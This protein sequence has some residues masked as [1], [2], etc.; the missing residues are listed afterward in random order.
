MLSVDGATAVLL[1]RGLIDP[2]WI[3]DGVLT[4]RAVA[5][6][7]RNL[8]VEGPGG[9]GF[10]LKQ[11]DNPGEG[12]Y[13]PLRREAA[14]YRFCVDETALGP[15]NTFMPRLV[16]SDDAET[17]L[18]FDLIVGATSLW[19]RLQAGVEEQLTVD[20]ARTLGRALGTLHRILCLSDWQDDP[21]L[22]R[23]S[24]DLPWVLGVHQP[25][26]SSLGSIS[27]ANLAIVRILQTEEGLREQFDRLTGRWRP[28][29]VIHGDIRLDNVLIRPAGVGNEDGT[30]ELW[31]ADWEAVSFGDPA[32]DVAGA[33]QDFL[34]YWVFSMP[35]SDELT[36]EQMIAQARVPVEGL[37]GALRA[38]WWG[39]KAGAS[40]A[41]SEAD[42][43]L[44]RAVAL[45]A[46]RL[47]QSAYEISSGSDRLA[48]P[49]VV[50][51]QIAANLLAE[52]ERGQIEL[53]GIPLGCPIP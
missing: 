34:V 10:L 7:N 53:Y 2:A 9:A 42:D 28:G 48:G 29:S 46:A 22:A 52:P 21:R 33:L 5:R 16:L 39:Y 41:G 12:D 20:A 15:I 36:A 18:V 25:V 3:V 27:R 19:S 40:L 31:I 47:I 1:E 23:L 13:Q 44:L 35:T 37:R 30:V 8:W 38:L 32:W 6:R 17:L 11:P 51:L 49:S 14:F 24:R 45:S 4:I 26:P 43:M 50:L